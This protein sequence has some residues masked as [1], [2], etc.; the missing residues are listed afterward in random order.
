MEQITIYDVEP[1]KFND[2]LANALKEIPEFEMPE[3]AGF[4]KT[5]VSK[6]RPPANPEW[7]YN[8]AA[9]I[10]RQIYIRGVVGV[11]RL[12]LRYGSKKERGA[13]P[14][15]FKKAS[16]KIIRTILQ[17]AEKAE[18]LEKSE[19]KK[20]G[21]QLTK[22]GLSFMNEI[23]EKVKLEKPELKEEKQ[24]KIVNEKNKDVSKN[25]AEGSDIN[26]KP[27]EEEKEISGD[28]KNDKEKENI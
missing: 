11:N 4:V 10:L 9:S 17:Q 13:R 25:D 28:N 20:K 21:R 24:D 8:R 22:K 7:W 1:E 3:W 12:K 6:L 23:A 2:E 5:S 15:K 14:E 26:N 16:G 19:T 27:K 18:F